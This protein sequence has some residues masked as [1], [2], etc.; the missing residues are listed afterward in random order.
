MQLRYTLNTLQM[1][2]FFGPVGF[3]SYRQN[4][5]HPAV[6]SQVRV[7]LCTVE[8]AAYVL[9]WYCDGPGTRGAALVLRR[10]R[11][12]SVE[13]NPRVLLSSL[14]PPTAAIHTFLSTATTVPRQVLDGRLR[15]VIPLDVAE[16]RLVLPIPPPPAAPPPAWPTTTAG[17]TI[18]TLACCLAALLCCVGAVVLRHWL[19][20]PRPTLATAVAI[21]PSEI[22]VR[23]CVRQRACMG[24]TYHVPGWCASPVRNGI[25]ALLALGRTC[26][27]LC[28]SAALP[29]AG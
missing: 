23:A 27:I 24:V 4:Y 7:A 3:N 22:H 14:Q 12:G 21:D 26:S 10:L 28:R 29:L 16:A 15:G 8:G 19:R 11:S 6:V 17:T 20:D 9:R 1:D 25:L 18:I 2:T 13:R 5:I